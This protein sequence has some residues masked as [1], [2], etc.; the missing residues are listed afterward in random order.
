MCHKKINMKSRTLALLLT[1]GGMLSVSAQTQAPAATQVST[2]RPA[3]GIGM[4]MTTDQPATVEAYFNVKLLPIVAGTIQT[5]QK[6][7]GD[8]FS[9]GEKLLEIEPLNAPG[10]LTPLLAP[11]DGVVS[12]RY[13]DPGAFVS[14][15]AVI[16][17]VNPILDL[18]RTD[19]VTVTAQVPEAFA[20]FLNDKTR[21]EIRIDALPGQV[22]VCKPTRF[23]PNFTTDDRTRQVQ[24]DMFNG[25]AAE[26]DAFLQKLATTPSNNLKSG[27]QPILP[28]GLQAGSAAGLMPGMFGSMKLV[29]SRFLDVPLIPSSA[30]LR[31]GGV[32]FLVKAENGVARRKPIHIEADNG[33]IAR[34]R[35]SEGGQVSELSTQDEIIAANAAAI[36]EGSPV[37]PINPTPPKSD[38]QPEPN[39]Q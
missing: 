3:I 7:I 23:A 20:T 18:Q 27:K 39:K 11:F 37:E 6:D 10:T 36:E 1:L 14:S 24:V 5:L 34:V 4:E 8:K 22:F 16:P 2:I 32:P 12:A 17:D 38:A 19:I 21:V 28:E 35:W 13:F 26:F 30:I 33:T 25:T 29:L 15:A 31:Q 9:S